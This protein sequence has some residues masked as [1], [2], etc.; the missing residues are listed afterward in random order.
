MAKR[1]ISFDA[2]EADHAL[3]TA[4]A[5]QEGISPHQLAR[6]LVSDALR[7]RPNGNGRLTSVRAL[8]DAEKALAAVRAELGG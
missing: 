2:G 5:E 7:N 3:L 6:R 4:Q 1:V 8:R